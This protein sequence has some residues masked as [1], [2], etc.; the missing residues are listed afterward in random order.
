MRSHWPPLD[1][2][3][4]ARKKE[5]FIEEDAASLGEITSEGSDAVYPEEVRS[6]ACAL[7]RFDSGLHVNFLFAVHGESCLL[8][9]PAREEEEEE[10][11]E[12]GESGLTVDDEELDLSPR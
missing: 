3:Y 6:A 4:L 10:E 8:L 1:H 5:T 11:G 7:R 12:G 9:S 2:T